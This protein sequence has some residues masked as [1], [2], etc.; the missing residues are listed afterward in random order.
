MT[1]EE[2]LIAAFG[3]D[4]ILNHETVFKSS[5]AAMDTYAEQTA[6]EF[7]EWANWNF[8]WEDKDKWTHADTTKVYTTTELFTL[9]KSQN[10]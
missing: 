7:I 3:E 1:R 4:F 8:I 5:L 2:I 6:T 9:Y 10:P